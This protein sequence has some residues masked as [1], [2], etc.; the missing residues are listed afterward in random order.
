MKNIKFN[1]HWSFLLLGILMIIFGKF[2]AFFSCI[3]C[4]ILHEM[5][6]AFIGRKLGYKLNIITLMPYG[7][8]LGGKNIHIN[9]NDEIKIAIAGPIVNAVLIIFCFLFVNFFP[10]TY[11]IFQYFIFANIYTLIFNLLPVYPMDGGRILLA[12]ISNKIGRVKAYKIVRIIGYFVTVTMFMLFIISA[13]FDLNYMLGINSLF[14]LVCLMEDDKEIYY[15]KVKSFEL[16]NSNKNS[17][18]N[19]ISLD[20]DNTIFDAYKKLIETN[21]KKILINYKDKKIELGRNKI[22]QD[23]LKFPIN[24]KLCDLD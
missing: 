21:A 24:T 20:K 13:F 4:V 10:E 17:N 18:T 12:Y 8:M 14:M 6:H 7:A 19:F 2:Q 11:N 5:G 23:I 16:F 1:I 22:F 3:I 9:N 15:Q